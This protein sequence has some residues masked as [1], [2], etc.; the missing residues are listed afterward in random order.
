MNRFHFET[1]ITLLIMA[2]LF[3]VLIFSCE[4]E[5]YQIDSSY[6]T[7]L[8]L[9]D[10][11]VCTP[12]AQG[13]DT[14]FI[15]E[16]YQSA[17]GIDHLYGLLIVKNGYLVAER[18]FNGKNNNTALP[19]ASLTKSFTSTLCGIALEQGYINSLDQTMVEFFPEFDWEDLDPLKSQIT[20]RQILKMR[21][22]YPWEEFSE[23]NDLLWDNFGNWLP[24][25]EQIPLAF[26]PGTNFG[27]SNLMS[28][29]LGIIISRAV[30]SSLHD[31][32]IK[33]LLEPLQIEIPVWW[34]DLEGYNYGH[35]DIHCSARD[36]ARFGEIYLNDGMSRAYQVISSD[37]I[38]DAL[39]PYSFDLYDGDIFDQLQEL[40]LGYMNWFSAQA[41]KHLVNFSWGAGGQH[42][43]L[44]RKHNLI[45]VTTAYYMPGASDEDSW[46]KQKSVTD[47]VGKYISNLP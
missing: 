31:F 36:L 21:S 16:M 2:L 15:N 32:A 41:G 45:I 8:E 24:L 19:I 14:A 39:S 18:Y 27:Y 25:V 13:L 28:H 34:T 6:Y 30:D 10:W 4:K 20:I 40:N 11:D 47:M 37:W 22:G 33:H 29:I 3:A 7:P 35:G 23:Y 44:L 12:E 5:K 26:E 46:E 42:I 38:A 1:G 9:D 43:F 17:S